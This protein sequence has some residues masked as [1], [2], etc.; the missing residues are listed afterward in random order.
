MLLNVIQIQQQSSILSSKI[1]TLMPLRIGNED[2]LRKVLSLGD[3]FEGKPSFFN[4]EGYSEENY[5]EP[6]NG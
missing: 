2:E 6:W 1:R 3:S 4:L 5:N